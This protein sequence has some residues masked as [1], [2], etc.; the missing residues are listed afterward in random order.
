MLLLTGE[1]KAQQTKKRCN[2]V[3]IKS[4]PL[5][6]LSVEFSRT[7]ISQCS[8]ML[9]KKSVLILLIGEKKVQQT[10]KKVQRSIYKELALDVAICIIFQ[11]KNISMFWYVVSKFLSR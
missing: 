5:P 3:F 6:L 8:G 10:K 1:K 9:Y 4:P 11:N 7:K 2:A